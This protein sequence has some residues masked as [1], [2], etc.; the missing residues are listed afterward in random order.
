MRVTTGVMVDNMMRNLQKNIK[1]L[2]EYNRQL[3]SGK[4]FENPSQNP[5]GAIN[6]MSLKSSLANSEQY[7]KN[8]ESAKDWLNNTESLLNSQGDI[9]QRARE[10]AVRAA[11]DTMDDSDR[12]YVQEEIKELRDE[13]INIANSQIAG[14]YIFAGQMTKGEK[15]PFDDS[16][17][18]NGVKFK[19]DNKEIKRE[20]GA[21]IEMVI[22]IDGEEAFKKAINTLRGFEELLGD[23]DLSGNGKGNV[24]DDI[25][26]DGIGDP[27]SDFSVELEDF[28]DVIGQ[29]DDLIDDNL[30]HR[31]QVGAKVNRLELSLNRTEDNKLHTRETLSKNEDVDIAEVITELKM[32]ESIYR[33]SLAVG[34][35]IIQPSLVDFI[36]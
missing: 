33:A 29:I 36:K 12:E 7:I 14:K 21:G 3:A 8:I 27:E 16:E 32:Q 23:E 28:S 9:L 2:D 13:L 6:S 11:N 18:V 17:S 24:Y 1:R 34:A 20:I 30:Q 5:I 31:A 15:S 25:D 4:K 19:G 26:G 35:R 10:L 22:N